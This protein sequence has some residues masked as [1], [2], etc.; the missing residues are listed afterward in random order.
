VT[1][2]ERVETERLVLRRPSTDDLDELHR[3]HADPRT[4][5]HKPELRHGSRDESTRQLTV[6][7]SHW[8]E[9]G[10]GYWTI[11]REGLVVGFGG[12]MLLPRWQGKRDVLNLYYR[13]DPEHWGNGY[14]TEMARAAV[15]LARREL[16]DLP[17][18]ARI[19][20]GNRESIRVAERTGLER[21]PE[22]D[23]GEFLVYAAG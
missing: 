1:P 22:W 16:P 23:D 7:L 6:W 2:F 19:R 3:I 5:L 9:R 10:Y 8:K 17:V 18:I 20:P 14:A 11:E 13:F 12:L 15:E 21:R 4:W